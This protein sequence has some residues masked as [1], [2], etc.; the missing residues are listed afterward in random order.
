LG[1]LTE[2]DLSGKGLG[3]LNIETVESGSD[4]PNA[5]PLQSLT[6]LDVAD[7]SLTTIPNEIGELA[8]LEKL[9]LSNNQLITLP[10][11]TDEVAGIDSLASLD[12]LKIDGNNIVAEDNSDLKTFLDSNS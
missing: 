8:K 6:T 1:S 12:E 3:A 9:N 7:N 4:D 11:A 5:K 2:L 10:T